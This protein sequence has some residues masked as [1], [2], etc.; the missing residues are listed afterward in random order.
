[1]CEPGRAAWATP[2]LGATT[3]RPFSR[4]CTRRR[5]TARRSAVASFVRGSPHHLAVLCT[6]SPTILLVALL[7][8]VCLC[9][10]L[11]VPLP[12]PLPLFQFFVLFF[13]VNLVPTVLAPHF[14]CHHCVC[15]C[16]CHSP[17]GPASRKVLW[18]F[19]VGDDHMVRE[20]GA[21]NVFFVIETK[22]GRDELITASL[23]D[24][25]ILPGVVRRS[26]LELVPPILPLS[27]AS[28]APAFAR[29][30]HAPLLTSPRQAFRQCH[31]QPDVVCRRGTRGSS[32]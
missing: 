14:R 21:M 1:M 25:D 29:S 12:P 16:H 3:D 11:P 18:L 22:D 2:K 4:R 8:S 5:K 13:P 7:L 31:L 26:I 32:W 27:R 9:H 19:P 15:P 17:A 30:D 23:D 10:P 20:V 6:I 28:L 24:G